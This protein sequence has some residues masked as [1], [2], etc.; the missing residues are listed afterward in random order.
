MGGVSRR[1]VRACGISRAEIC[2][3]ACERARARASGAGRLKKNGL[4]RMQDG[5]RTQSWIRTRTY[6]GQMVLDGITA[7]QSC[8]Q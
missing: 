6:L 5:T 3:S 1:E 4:V 8:L 2:A 7:P